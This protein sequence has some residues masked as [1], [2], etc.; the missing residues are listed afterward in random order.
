[1]AAGSAIV[2]VAV[3]KDRRFHRAH[4]KPARRRR[5]RH[6]VAAGVTEDTAIAAFAAVVGYRGGG[7]GGPGRVVPV[8][9]VVVP[10][11][12][13]LSP[14]DVLALLTGRRGENLVWTDLGA[15]RRRLLASPWVRDATLRRSLPSTVE[16]VLAEREPIG[17]GRVNGALYLVDDRGAVIDEYGP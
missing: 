5:P 17:I 10:R 7:E 12:T 4:V 13:R 9:R 2:S 11:H 8:G 16:V 6:G 1:R 15:W 3:S 14:G